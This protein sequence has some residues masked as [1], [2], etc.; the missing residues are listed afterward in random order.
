MKIAIVKLSALGD[1]VHA[2]VVLQYIKKNFPTATIHWFVEGRFAGVLENNPDIDALHKVKLKNNTLNFLK[3]YKKL[4]KLAPYDLVIDLQ[5]LI[6]SSIISRILSKN[7]VGFDKN[8]LR[9]PLASLFYS[10]KHSIPY[11]ENVILR[12]MQLVSKAL[13]FICP[14]LQLKEPFLYYKSTIDIHPTLLIVAG[15]SWKSKIYSKEKFLD[16]INALQ[17]KTFIAWGDDEEKVTA[18]F[19]CNHTKA[20]M[21]PKL[22]LDELKKVIANSALVIGGDSGPTHMA[23]ALNIP[24]ITIFGPTPSQ[25]NTLKT[26]INLTVDCDKIINAKELDKKDFCIQQ[27]E[28]EKIIKKAKELLK[29]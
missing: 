24:S 27:I 9:E 14:D 17:I 29:C 20:T 26:D 12:N 1:I 23:W 3:E 11:E 22:S 2:M 5:G 8:S 16:I 6:K 25:R 13:N 19:I 18:Q 10:E 7:I 28:P 4:K 21:L 15:S